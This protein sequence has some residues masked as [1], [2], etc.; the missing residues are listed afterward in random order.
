M[1]RDFRDSEGGFVLEIQVPSPLTESTESL[2][3]SNRTEQQEDPGK[4]R[5]QGPST[6]AGKLSA[7]D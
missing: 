3:S 4:G 6:F 7:K 1:K 5:T 2:Q